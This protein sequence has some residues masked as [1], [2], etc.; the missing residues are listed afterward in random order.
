M[1]AIFEHA[2]ALRG[3]ASTDAVW[4]VHIVRRCWQAVVN[5]QLEHAAFAQLSAMSDCQLRDMGLARSEIGLA[6]RGELQRLDRARS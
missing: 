5:W 3:V 1:N 2:T 4:A 6:V